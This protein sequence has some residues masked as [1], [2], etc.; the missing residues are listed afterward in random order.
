[1]SFSDYVL[2]YL[3]ESEEEML[4]DNTEEVRN[5]I[6]KFCSDD[7]IKTSLLDNSELFGLKSGSNVLNFNNSNVKNVLNMLDNPPKTGSGSGRSAEYRCFGLGFRGTGKPIIKGKV[8]SSG[9]GNTTKYQEIGPLIFMSMI[10]DQ[11]INPEELDISKVNIS[12]LKRIHVGNEQDIE[13]T[14]KFL[15]T[16]KSWHK[17]CRQQAIDIVKNVKNIKEYQFHHGTTLF[18]QIKS[19]GKTLSEISEDKWNPSDIFLTKV[20]SIPKFDNITEYNEY[21]GSHNDVV[22]I[23]LKKG[24]KDA[25]L[26]K[27][28]IDHVY[29]MMSLPNKGEDLT[30]KNGKLTPTQVEKIVKVLK[31]IKGIKS[32]KIFFCVTRDGDIDKG[33]LS[34]VQSSR[35]DSKNYGKSFYRVIDFL[36]NFKSERDLSDT[37]FLMLEIAKSQASVSCRHYKWASKFEEITPGLDKTKY[38]FHKLRIPLDGDMHAVSE[39]SYED[40]RYKLQI[41]SFGSLPQV[42]IIPLS[43]EERV[44]NFIVAK[45]I[46]A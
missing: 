30:I 13:Q 26:G 45:K 15:S 46:K 16:D 23:S 14:I 10:L 11:G 27:F 5:I 35:I 9:G 42:E 32:D 7:K 31:I 36:S 22:G 17:S 18:R 25:R 20:T 43:K 37:L 44:K 21:I 2:G 41:R 6:K 1:M 39:V 12:K 4:I 28:A 24:A 38:K 19:Q 33:L 40:H 8:S 34:C 29:K 3:N